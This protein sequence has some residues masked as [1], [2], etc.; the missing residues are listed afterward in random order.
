[1]NLFGLYRDQFKYL[2]ENGYE[3]TGLAPAG[4]EH[5]WLRKQGFNTKV[6]HLKRPPSIFHDLISL[7]QL[8]LYLIFNRFDIINISTPKASLIGSLAAYFTFHKNIVYNLRG[9]AY[10]MTNGKTRQFYEF[11][12]KLICGI[13]SKVLCD[14]KE[15][16]QDIIESG[17]CSEEKIKVFGSGSSNGVDLGKFTKNTDILENGLRIRENLGIK[18]NDILVLN[19]GR[20]RKDKGIN[21]LVRSFNSISKKYQNVHLLLQGKF[22][23]FD[24]LD[25]D[26]M[27]LIESHSRIHQAGW[28]KKVEYYF[29][30]ADIFAFPSHREGFGNVAIEASA[31]EIPVVAF[32]VIGCRE[33][34]KDN[35][36][37]ILCTN[38]D[39]KSFEQGL[40][41]L[42]KN[43]ILRE[44]LG[45]KGRSRVESEFNSI[46]IWEQLLH[47]Y[48]KVTEKGITRSEEHLFKIDD[49]N[50]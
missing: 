8:T 36:S 13:S 50:K 35:V 20:L 25:K 43:D 21:E 17:L 1:M 19:S 48:N 44:D 42:I 24:P 49:T 7:C 23:T 40:E 29:A 26:V 15:I 3:V 47:E 33:S 10:E 41:T 32:N 39:H 14:S 16:R 34:V 11:I 6:I 31:M 2:R 38:I 45:R 30:A 27:K 22:E 18:E 5:E 46:K 37:G 4:E 28:V 12:E 9:R